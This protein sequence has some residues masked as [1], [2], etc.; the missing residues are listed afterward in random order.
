MSAWAGVSDHFTRFAEADGV[1]PRGFAERRLYGR[2][3]RDLL[4][5]AVGTG[6][7]RTVEAMAV[8]ARRDDGA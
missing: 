2:Y 4:D 3:L 1:G 7:V 8:G 6:L 5:E